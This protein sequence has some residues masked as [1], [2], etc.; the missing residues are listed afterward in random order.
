MNERLRE[1]LHKI[2]RQLCGTVMRCATAAAPLSITNQVQHTD[3]AGNG[4]GL[5]HAALT[6][7]SG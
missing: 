7:A 6:A 2:R 3:C 5:S 4:A 1:A